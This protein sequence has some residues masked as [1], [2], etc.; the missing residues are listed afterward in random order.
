MESLNILSQSLMSPES[1]KPAVFAEDTPRFG[2]EMAPAQ[3]CQPPDVFGWDSFDTSIEDSLE[4]NLNNLPHQHNFDTEHNYELAIDNTPYQLPTQS[5]SDTQD[6]SPV[7]RVTGATSSAGFVMASRTR[8]FMAS[9]ETARYRAV[10]VVWSTVGD[11]S[12]VLGVLGVTGTLSG[13]VLPSC[14]FSSDNGLSQL[15]ESSS[16]VS[17]SI[18]AVSSITY[19]SGS[20]A[21]AKIPSRV[22]GRTGLSMLNVRKF[23][24][25]CG[26]TVLV[27]NELVKSIADPTTWPVK[28][29][30]CCP[31]LSMKFFSWNF[32]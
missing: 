16:S 19:N 31:V 23:S 24:R 27:Y 21:V 3:A 20:A 15:C 14:R 25:W 4:H 11:V 5:P 28:W 8:V 17:S 26:F 10:S 32:L 1:P 9:T 12:A 22:A 29:F 30:T 13:V 7:S 6:S 2:F 18:A